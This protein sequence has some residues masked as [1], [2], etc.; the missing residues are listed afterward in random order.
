[1]QPLACDTR[2]VTDSLPVRERFSYWSEAVIGVLTPLSLQDRSDGEFKGTLIAYPVDTLSVAHGICPPH[3]VDRTRMNLANSKAEFVY[4]VCPRKGGLV[5]RQFG[6]TAHVGPNQCVLLTGEERFTMDFVRD[7]DSLTVQIPHRLISSRMPTIRD[8]CAIELTGK[9][10]TSTALAALVHALPN[11]PL[12]A[13]AV[14][15]HSLAQVLIN[16]LE[17]SA[18]EA[19]GE[20]GEKRLR[21]KRIR[22]DDVLAFIETHLTDPLLTPQRA[23]TALGVSERSIYVAMEEIG[24]SFMTC[25]RRKRLEKITAAFSSSTNTDQRIAD[26]V[27][28]WGFNDLSTFHRAFRRTYDLTPKEYIQAHRLDG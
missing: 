13:R 26:I 19:L 21:L 8:A 4:L 7:M 9:A 3:S 5:A 22:S 18:K 17:L 15:Q 10:A 6:R 1:M 12:R 27:F 28:E 25:A 23:S 16:L 14:L 11:N 20:S 2:W 24:E